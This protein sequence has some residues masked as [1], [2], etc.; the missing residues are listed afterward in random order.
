M[1]ISIDLQEWQKATVQTHPALAEVSL[2]NDEAVEEILQGMDKP[3]TIRRLRKGIEIETSSYV[4]RIL[5]GGLQITIRPKIQMMC[6]SRLMCYAYSLP[7]AHNLFLPAEFDVEA[8][9]FQDLLIYQ[10][11]SEVNSLLSRGLQR[12][13]VRKEENLLSLRGRIV[14][15]QIANRGGLLQESLPCDYHLRLDDCLLNQVLL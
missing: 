3:L 1:S 8:F 5:L 9:A 7:D 6:L 4:G 11:A 10:L 14:I 12:Q 2:V 13:Y 15:S